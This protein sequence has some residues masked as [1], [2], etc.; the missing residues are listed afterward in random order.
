MA[1]E[2]QI[3]ANRRNGNLGKGP[4]TDDGK[5]K[6]RMNAIKHGLT[7][8]GV[9]ENDTIAAVAERKAE[10]GWRVDLEK[11]ENEMSFHVMV[12]ASVVCD[13]GFEAAQ[14]YQKEFSARARANWDS[15]RRLIAE[16]QA[17]RLAKS[18]GLVCRQLEGTKQGA[19]L[20]LE[21]WERLGAT[22]ESGG[23]WSES[24]RSHALDLL[25]VAVDLRNGLT[26]VDAR[27][28]E[29]GLAFRKAVVSRQ[30]ERLRK[31]AGS[32]ASLDAMQRD[33]AERG[34][35]AEYTKAGQLIERYQ[36]EAARRFLKAREELCGPPPAAAPRS[37]GRKSVRKSIEAALAEH[38]EDL[39]ERPARP[40]APRPMPAAVD[41]PAQRIDPPQPIAP[42]NVAPNDMS[43]YASLLAS[44]PYM[45]RHERRAAQAKA[46]RRL[47]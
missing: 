33:H 39:K 6:S 25:G 12:V 32:L 28:G 22:L 21:R 31:L 2:A 43:L 7:G 35:L 46:R 47:S 36:R 14:I 9:A 4:V 16:T 5:A 10:W 42:V 15:D 26:P 18:P 20:M 37:G 44:A 11:P 24:E 3:A 29:D 40:E 38:V 1:S 45:N 41:P 13:R 27:S 34:Y 17:M 19:E 30:I 8:A 23:D